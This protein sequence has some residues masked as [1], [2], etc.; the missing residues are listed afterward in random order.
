MKILCKGQPNYYHG[1]GHGMRVADKKKQLP[2]KSAL[3]KMFLKKIPMT[4]KNRNAKFQGKF[5]SCSI[6]VMALERPALHHKL[7]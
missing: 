4:K 6:Y 7:L 3:Q 1:G 5:L 2:L